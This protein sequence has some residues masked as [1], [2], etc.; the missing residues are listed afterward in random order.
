M[1]VVGTHRR[2]LRRC[3]NESTRRQA[4]SLTNAYR[5]R[6]TRHRSHER[7]GVVHPEAVS[8]RGLSLEH[9]VLALSVD[10]VQLH[11]RRDDQLT[12]L[13]RGQILLGQ[14]R[15]RAAAAAAAR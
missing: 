3:R 5:P 1:D 11:P 6:R 10:P 14:D 4:S 12:R 7:V 9:E 8:D 13:E 15:S 2:G